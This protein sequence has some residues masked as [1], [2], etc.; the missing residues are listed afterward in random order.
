MKSRTSGVSNVAIGGDALGSL[1]TGCSNTVVGRFSGNTITT[2][3]NNVLVGDV[4]ALN[5][6]AP[7]GSV[8]IG[9]SADV[10]NFGSCCNV[11]VGYSAQ[12]PSAGTP[13]LSQSV[14]LG[15]GAMSRTAHTG[16]CVVAIGPDVS[17][18]GNNES[19]ALVIG[20]GLNNW[21]CGNSSLA[22]KF[23]AGIIDCAGSCGTAGQVLSSNGS[24][25]LE[26][27]AGGGGGSNAT[28][29][30][31]G[32]VFGYVGANLKTDSST[33]VGLNSL[34]AGS[35]ANTPS[36]AA[37]GVRALQSLNLGGGNTAVGW[38]SLEATTTGQLNTAIGAAAGSN[39]DGVGNT[40]VGQ[41]AG[42]D[43]VGDGNTFFGS[44]AAQAQVSGDNNV[45]IGP[46][47]ALANT[48]G[49]C[50]LA[51]GFS[52]TDNW[53]T[54]DSTKA[55]KPGA[56]IIDSSSSTGS[57]GQVLTSTGSNG[58]Q[59]ATAASPT[60]IYN[61]LIDVTASTAANVIGWAGERGG[62]TSYLQ[63]GNTSAMLFITANSGGNGTDPRAWAQI[64]IASL[65]DVGL[66]QIIASNT[67]G[68]TWSIGGVL[69]PAFSDTTIQ[70]T[71]STTETPMLFNIV[72]TQ[73]GGF[74]EPV[75]VYGT[76]AT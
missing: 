28:P 47:T 3:C 32:L 50:Q 24:N 54:G 30:T 10:F 5:G 9:S 20:Y 19:C 33:S 51:I 7:S 25:A 37:L 2:Q 67:S 18:G 40:I 45:A 65:G 61:R 43:V 22:I 41:A 71:S 55:I 16:D 34:A 13:S 59:W 70:Y 53:L 60:V 48:T 8:V 73:F 42:Q 69:Y 39:A 62:S 27:V 11:I 58:L 12:N 23:G 36:N 72:L 31:S 15:A 44:G 68:G 64:M 35:P 76:P 14:I 26:W 21:I 74:R 56:G 1:T 49:S 4:I 17:L 6:A 29:T 57:A 75:I 46:G 52:G 63:N 66:S 38:A